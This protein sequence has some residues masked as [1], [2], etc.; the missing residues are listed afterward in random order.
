MSRLLVIDDVFA[1]QGRG[2]AV[3]G[4]RD[5]DRFFIGDQV[6]IRR[7]DGSKRTAKIN[8][9]GMG[10][11]LSGFLDL[12]LDSSITKEDVSVGDEVWLLP[13]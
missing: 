8:G 5:G 3:I 12:L 7:R 11:A 4:K 9:I 2:V 13:K 6:E 1:I 10:T